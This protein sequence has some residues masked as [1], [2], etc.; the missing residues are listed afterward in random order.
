MIPGLFDDEFIKHQTDP[1]D[2]DSD[3]DGLKDG[4]EVNTHK[5]DPNKIDTDRD[6]A[7][8]GLEVN[9]LQQSR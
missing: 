7:S 8:D 9:P 4:A 2:P 3:D 6:W 5:T 1:L